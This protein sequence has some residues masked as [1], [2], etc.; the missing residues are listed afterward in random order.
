[1]DEL[2]AS[3]SQLI[4]DIDPVLL[5]VLTAVVVIFLTIVLLKFAKGGRKGSHVVFVGLC[6]A[7]KTLIFSKLAHGRHITTHTSMK[8]NL[9]KY[10][11]SEKNKTV[12]IVDIP[13]HE[14][15]RQKF[16][17]Q[18]KSLA[19]A[20]VFVVDSTT[21]QKEYKD[22]AE[23]LYNLLTDAVISRNCPP[24]LMLCNKQDYTLAKGAKVIQTQLQKEINTLRKTR[25]AALDATDGDV[26]NNNTFLGKRNKD[27]EFTDIKPFC[28]EFAECSAGT[29]ADDSK[30]DEL[31]QWIVKIS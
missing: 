16:V 28:V 5:G 4:K 26:G 3:F 8:E 10:T 7:G 21:F 18:Y 23:Y 30:L 13:G 22:V 24:I 14:R 11:I 27:F 29:S 12:Q 1:M 17:D 9:G 19:R 15:S 2:K 20:I 31:E 6:D 25:A